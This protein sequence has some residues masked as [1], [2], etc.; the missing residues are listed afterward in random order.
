MLNMLAYNLNRGVSDVRLFEAGA[1]FH[2]DDVRATEVKHIC[3]GA[4]GS[5]VIPS[6]H[7]P[8]RQ[9]SFFDVKGDL[10]ALLECFQHESVR[11]ES[12]AADYYHPGRSARILLDGVI[13]VQ[14]G[15]LHP[16]V[17]A[18]RKLRQEV[19]LAELFLDRLY[20]HPLRQVR[21]QPLPKYPAV[22]R[23][24][25]FIFEDSVIFQTI[26]RSVADLHLAELRDFVP[27]ETFHGGSIPSGKHSLLLRATFQSH[28]RTLRDDEV[29]AWSAQIIA[30]LASLGGVQRA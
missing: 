26:Y 20:R 3:L 25:S 17:A 4:T 23:D 9:F 15:Q 28:Q 22:D 19:F 5:V 21:Y 24:F 16:E 1:V 14:F 11:F 27:V 7:N 12:S 29:G 8:G 10:E 6:V 30:A 2:R 13:V 18:A